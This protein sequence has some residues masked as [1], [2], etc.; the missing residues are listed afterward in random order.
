M[1][2]EVAIAYYEVLFQYLYRSVKKITTKFWIG[3]RPVYNHCNVCMKV[4]HM[5]LQEDRR[6]Q[7]ILWMFCSQHC[8][9]PSD[10]IFF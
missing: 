9:Y 5:L 6:W 8:S 10:L 3:R 1:S 7:H 2:Y 4:Y